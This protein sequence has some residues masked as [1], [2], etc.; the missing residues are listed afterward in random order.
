M[1]ASLCP[2]GIERHA[3][4]NVIPCVM[5]G[6]SAGPVYTSCAKLP[7]ATTPHTMQSLQID[8]RA[9]NASG[10]AYIFVPEPATL[11][12]LALGGLTLLRRR[13]GA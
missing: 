11:T 3:A 9:G 7:D 1:G 6:R 5:I 13:R 8:T 2:F 10:S 4:D 12:L